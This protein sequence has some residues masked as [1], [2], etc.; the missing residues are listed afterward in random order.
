MLCRSGT[1]KGDV[2]IVAWDG[3]DVP[4]RS[5]EVRGRTVEVCD[6]PGRC[7]VVACRSREVPC[8]DRLG[9]IV[10]VRF[11]GCVLGNELSILGLVYISISCR[12]RELTLALM[13]ACSI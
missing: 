10:G 13:Y 6:V 5:R 3:V 9:E 11:L 12:C 7:V 1:L 8:C 2:P 4:C